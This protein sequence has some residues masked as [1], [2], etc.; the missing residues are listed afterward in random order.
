MTAP[1]L[2]TTWHEHLST[3]IDVEG[4]E[5]PHAFAL[6]A[7]QKLTIF[8]LALP[9]GDGY[10]LMTS[11][12]ESKKYQELVFALDR[13]ALPGQGTQLND[14]LAGWHFT[15]EGPRPFIVEYRYEPREIRPIDW[16]NAHWNAALERELVSAFYPGLVR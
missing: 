3:S 7:E 2:L 9:C 1:D 16:G 13:Y 5:V 15:F 6:D 12:W 4:F 11:Q 14:L 10:R 8:A